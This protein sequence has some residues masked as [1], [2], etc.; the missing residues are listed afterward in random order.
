LRTINGRLLVNG[1]ER[2]RATASGD[3]LPLVDRV[4]E[5]LEAVGERLSAG[6][7]LITGSIVQVPV[8]HGDRVRA[9]LGRLGF[10]EAPIVA[11]G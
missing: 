1:R 7:R 10:A 5:L 2:A 11:G 9:D 8:R 3:V 4:G 6:D